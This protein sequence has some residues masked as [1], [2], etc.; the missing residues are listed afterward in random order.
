VIVGQSVEGEQ[1]WFVPVMNFV[2]PKAAGLSIVRKRFTDILA[3][4][5][6][7]VS[8]DNSENGLSKMSLQSEFW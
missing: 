4:T 5:L 3:G 1:A 7:T 6:D 2:Q 8:C